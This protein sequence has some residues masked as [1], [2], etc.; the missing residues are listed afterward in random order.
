MYIY[1]YIYIYIIILFFY[2][3]FFI[4]NL[5]VNYITQLSVEYIFGAA[6]VSGVHL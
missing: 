1:I 4:I 5:F 6:F 2:F 3:I